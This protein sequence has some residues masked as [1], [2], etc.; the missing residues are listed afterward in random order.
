MANNIYS[1]MIE[2]QY[3]NFLFQKNSISSVSLNG[4]D[5]EYFTLYKDHFNFIKKYYDEYRQLPSKETFQAKFNDQWEWVFVIDPEEYLVNK[6]RE[7]KLFRDTVESYKKMGELLKGEKTD[8]AIELMKSVS[9]NY[10]KVTTKEAVKLIGDANKRYE[11]Y[12]DRV[13][14]PSKHF[15]TTGLK[16]LDNVVGGWDMMNES[17]IVCAR[18]GIGKS[19][20]LTFFALNAAKAGLRVGYYSGEMEPDFI[21]YRLDTFEGNI[22]NGSLT[23]GN[24]NVME[25][26]KNYIGSLPK[27]VSGEVHCLT[28]DDFG[29]AATVSKLEAA[30]DKYGFDILCI[31]QLSLLDDERRG[32]TMPERYSN[33]SMDLRNLQRMIKKPI[34]CACQL[35]REEFEEG[36]NMRNIGGSD[37]IGQDATTA[38]FIEQKNGNAVITVG[39]ARNAKTGDKLTYAWNINMGILHYI[40]TENDAQNGDGTDEAEYSYATDSEKSDSVF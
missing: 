8:E 40:P 29:G 32:R 34:I 15:V 9:R 11:N 23:H 2:L 5:E 24:S 16:E 20:F 26:Y 12:L 37:R 6:L 14:N 13:N 27:V 18:T 30:I 35:N 36:V 19:W 1:A 7:A 28:P 10:T 31:D 39:K 3:L 22:A 17:A 4:I 25:Q 21:G 38:L 33:I